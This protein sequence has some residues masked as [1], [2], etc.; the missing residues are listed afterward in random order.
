MNIDNKNI[1]LISK[2]YKSSFINN[3]I[4]QKNYNIIYFGYWNNYYDDLNNRLIKKIKNISDAEVLYIS[5]KLK[6]IISYNYIKNNQLY[7]LDHIYGPALYWYSFFIKRV[8]VQFNFLEK[9]ILNNKNFKLIFSKKDIIQGDEFLFFNRNFEPT[10]DA[11]ILSHS[12]F[13]TNFILYHLSSLK[14][15]N[16]CFINENYKNLK[17]P[18]FYE[19]KQNKMYF[20]SKLRFIGANINVVNYQSYRK[21]IASRLFDYS[22]VCFSEI[23]KSCVPKLIRSRKNLNDLKVTIESL[24]YLFIPIIDSNDFEELVEKSNL[25]SKKIN[26]ITLS[27]LHLSSILARLI[28]FKLRNNFKNKIILFKEHGSSFFSKNSN[29]YDFVEKV[30]YITK[31]R[32]NFPRKVS[33]Y[34]I[35]S[36][37]SKPSLLINFIRLLNKKNNKITIIGQQ[38]FDDVRTQYEFANLLTEQKTE[39]F[40]SLT[41]FLK[42][43]YKV[44]FLPSK[45]S[46]F[47]KFDPLYEHLRKHKIRTCDNYTKALIDSQVL[48]VTYPQ[49]TIF[50]LIY[51]NI[52]FVLFLNP[53]E[54]HL[55]EES[56]KWYQQFVNFGLAFDYRESGKLYDFL[57]SNQIFKIFYSNKFNKFKKEFIRYVS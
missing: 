15:R 53:I 43:K 24:A 44:S 56:K 31:Y 35:G 55:T 49:T 40:V 27:S 42:K 11:H 54:W 18:K 41:N 9:I 28:I 48:I 51:L 8:M 2:D 57:E 12:S 52:P 3:L 10:F 21:R 20:Y 38:W 16:I 37:H 19:T 13:I 45:N 50:D 32:K 39:A 4:N 25:V 22:S 47:N 7:D 46:R 34:V 36:I 14:Y 17:K 5:Q 6:N 23:S 1:I 33:P 29:N 30:K 26:N